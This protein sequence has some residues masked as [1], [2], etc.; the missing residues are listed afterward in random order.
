MLRVALLLC[1]LC[2]LRVSC[3]APERGAGEHDPDLTQREV[4]FDFEGLEWTDITKDDDMDP[5]LQRQVPIDPSILQKLKEESKKE[6]FPRFSPQ[7]PHPHEVPFPPARPSAANLPNICQHGDRRPRYPL[8]SLPTTGFGRESRQGDCINRL[9]SWYPLCCRGDETQRLCCADQAWHLAL[10]DYCKEEFTVKT[11]HYHCCRKKGEAMWDCFQKDA[12]DT[13]Y[14]PPPGS[15]VRDMDFPHA[16]AEPGFQW[17]PETCQ[18]SRVVLHPRSS[19]QDLIPNLSFPPG[20]PSPSNIQRI[21]QL[22]K[23]RPRYPSKCLPRSGYGWFTRQSKALGQLEAGLKRCCKG[24]GALLDCAVR[25]WKVV[26][27]QYCEAVSSVKD[28]QEPCCREQGD[29]LFRCFADRAP[30]PGYDREVRN[31]SLSTPTPAALDAV[32]VEHKLL[33]KKSPVPELLMRL[34]T[35][36][37]PLREPRR[38]ACAQVEV[39]GLPEHLCGQR[40]SDWTDRRACCRL[41]LHKRARCIYGNKLEAVSI[42]TASP[43]RNKCPLI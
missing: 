35:Q 8:P 2:V 42:A 39:Q 31:L 6:N 15:E 38:T 5:L 36:C 41:P 33:S 26:L 34:K 11:S 23:L 4:T 20:Q 19:K 25:E 13:T 7:A 28:K 30:H 18:S 3:T 22:R 24:E 16:T 40:M 29:G 21:C 27:Q 43:D 12:P 10:S 1:W 9:E 17:D 32:C 37:C 14:L